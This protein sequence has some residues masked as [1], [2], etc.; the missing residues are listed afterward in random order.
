MTSTDVHVLF[1]N[2]T[3]TKLESATA[4]LVR[5]DRTRIEDVSFRFSIR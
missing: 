3:E 2:D 1:E 5:T 4:R